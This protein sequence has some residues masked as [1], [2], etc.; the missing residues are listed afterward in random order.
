MDSIAR[1]CL[2]FRTDSDRQIPKLRLVLPG[3]LQPP[4]L[5]GSMQKFAG[6]LHSFVRLAD[7]VD[8]A[9]PVR[10][11]GPGPKI[12]ELSPDGLP[13]TCVHMRCALFQLQAD[14]HDFAPHSVDAV[15]REAPSEACKSRGCG[16]DVVLV[17]PGRRPVFRGSDVD[18]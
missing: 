4:R 5:H 18:G 3:N 9:G 10:R 17:I 14:R 16:Y 6:V 2:Q 11:G 7:S 12:L 8:V 1:A 13:E 15:R